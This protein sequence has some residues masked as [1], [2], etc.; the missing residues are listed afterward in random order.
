MR[1]E[2]EFWVVWNPQGSNPTA[3]HATRESADREAERLARTTAGTFY[4][5]HAVS[6]SRRVD[7]ETVELGPDLPF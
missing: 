6:R 4:V 1:Q 2:P 5:L 3:R 7:I